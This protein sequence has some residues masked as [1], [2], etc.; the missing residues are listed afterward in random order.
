MD[1]ERK[2]TIH[3]SLKATFK[4]K[5]EK[6]KKEKFDDKEMIKK[7]PKVMNALQAHDWDKGVENL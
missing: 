2:A 6:K 1:L 5:K 7:S 4:K 3:S